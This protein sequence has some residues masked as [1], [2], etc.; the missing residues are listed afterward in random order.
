MS[1]V[2]PADE[3]RLPWL[4]PYRETM[5]Q[6]QRVAR[7]SH[8][9]LVAVVTALFLLPVGIGAGFWLGQRSDAHCLVARDRRLL[10]GLVARR[11][12]SQPHATEPPQLAVCRRRVVHGIARF[13]RIPCSMMRVGGRIGRARVRHSIEAFLEF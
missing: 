6:K 11:V 5:A 1:G 2:R 8:G 9:G 3:D 12:P 10:E 13:H 4:E 7:R